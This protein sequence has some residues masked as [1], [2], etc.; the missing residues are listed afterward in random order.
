MKLSKELIAKIDNGDAIDDAELRDAIVF[1]TDLVESLTCLG[2]EYFI[3][4]RPLRTVLFRLEGFQQ[5]R[6]ESHTK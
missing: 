1:Y 6:N 4:V 2:K 5:A 3:A